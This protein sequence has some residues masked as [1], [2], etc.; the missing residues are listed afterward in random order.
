MTNKE[1]LENYVVDKARTKKENG[2]LMDERQQL[3]TANMFMA[4]AVCA[5]LF[6]VIMMAIYVIKRDA[7]KS[8]PYL[9][10]LLVISVVFC[11]ASLGQK[12]P[13]LPATLS[14]RNVDPEKSGAAFAK[15]L[16]SYF[17]ESAV[18]VAAIT[19]LNVYVDG[20][21]TGS[22]VSDTIIT[23]V[24]FLLIEMGIG[25]LR[26]HRWRSWQKKLDDEEN[27]LDD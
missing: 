12:E 3:R 11:I 21:V 24:V 19:A 6:D 2:S 9:A 7:D 8:Y 14:G 1:R 4:A 5:M 23:L 10:Q 22:I 20:N 13:G 26:V 15:R 17:I 27:E 16:L 25:E 18:G